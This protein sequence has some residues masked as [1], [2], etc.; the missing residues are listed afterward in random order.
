VK[1][2]AGKVMKLP[3][4]ATELMMPARTAAKNRKTG[5]WIGGKC[6][7][8]DTRGRELS[9]VTDAQMVTAFVVDRVPR[10]GGK[11]PG[12]LPED[13]DWY[14]VHRPVTIPAIPASEAQA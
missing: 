13:W 2:K 6:T 9:E 11:S 7:R 10:I 14:T 5:W 8:K 3:P 1:I 12:F 4:P